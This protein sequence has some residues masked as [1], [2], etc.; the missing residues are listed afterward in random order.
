MNRRAVQLIILA[1]LVAVIGTAYF[2]L[3]ANYQQES[4]KKV[5]RFSSAQKGKSE[6]VKVSAHIVS[7]DPVKAEL[8]MRLQFEPHHDLVDQDD[9]LLYPL[10][11]YANSI[12]GKSEVSFKKGE[13]MQPLD[14]TLALDGESSR[15]PWDQYQGMLWVC[16]ASQKEGGGAKATW[17]NQPFSL[18]LKPGVSGFKIKTQEVKQK[19]AD[20]SQLSVSFFIERATSTVAFAVFIMILLGLLTMV[21]FLAGYVL[22]VG[23]RKIQPNVLGW[24]GAM[25]FAM[26]PLRNAMPGAPPI[27]CLADYLSFFWAEAITAAT[28]IA[29]VITW[30]L[31]KQEGEAS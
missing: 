3:L 6:G 10:T 21:D 20:F 13:S 24:L 28:L 26:V 16:L 4:R 19:G 31:R 7:F 25:L 22:I 5:Q 2:S 30:V 29:V 8:L 12:S 18:D 11:V 15:Y 1:V 23:K 14:V 27:G 9:L 17:Y